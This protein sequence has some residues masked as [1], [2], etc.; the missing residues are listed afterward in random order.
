MRRATECKW[1]NSD[2]CYWMFSLSE[3]SPWLLGSS[4]CIIASLIG[5]SFGH[6]VHEA[7]YEYSSSFLI[8]LLLIEI[9]YKKEKNEKTISH[10]YM[11]N[12]TK[13]KRLFF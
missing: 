8:I 10:K 13:K 12:F 4:Q 2:L 7:H 9:T 5:Q 3:V 6:L 1:L 11:I